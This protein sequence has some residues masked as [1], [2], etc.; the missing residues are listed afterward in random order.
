[1]SDNKTSATKNPESAIGKPSKGMSQVGR[2][3]LVHAVLIFFTFLCLF[4]FYVLFVNATRSHAELNRGFTPFFSKYGLMNAF[5]LVVPNSTV[6]L[7]SFKDS[8]FWKYVFSADFLVSCWRSNIV[9]GMF[10]SAVIAGASSLLC[11]YFSTMTAY[12]IHAYDFKFKKAAFMFILAIMML[13]TQISAL[14]FIRLVRTMKLMDNYIPLIV[15]AIAAPVTFFY[16]KQFMDSSLPHELLESARIDGAGEFRIFNTIALPL[17]KPAMSVQIIFS[18][19]GSW[20]N[21]FTPNLILEDQKLKTL[22]IMIA[23][24]RTADYLKFDMGKVNMMI[25]LSILP[26]MIVYVFLA[27]Y[28]V[29][30]MTVGA[31]KG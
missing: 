17:M 23:Q 5:N 18:F 2:H 14:G 12:A 3:I 15:P 21:Y 28:I 1:M 25:A 6:T 31:V 7:D 24:L 10:N 26:V 16:L 27:R 30:G 13:P 11:V 8:T 4:W 20:N 29:G 9:R 22:P 19:V